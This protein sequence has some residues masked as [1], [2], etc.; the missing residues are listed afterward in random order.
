MHY[1]F[2]FVTLERWFREN[3]RDLPWRAS[4]TPYS[5]WVSEV[6]LQQTQAS[7]VIPYFE[8]WMRR[9]PDVEAL[10]AAPLDE[11]IKMWEGLG[12]YSRAR[13]LH[14]G[15]RFIVESYGGIFPETEEDLKQIKG[16]G[17]Y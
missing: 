9:F 7:V 10:A 4:P 6:M 3:K 2:D 14:A 5:V 1:Q 8:R 15:S 12:Y 16:L 17:L 13:F 11:V